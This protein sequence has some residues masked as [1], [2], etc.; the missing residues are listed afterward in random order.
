MMNGLLSTAKSQNFVVCIFFLRIDTWFA[1][2]LVPPG[3]TFEGQ[4][5]LQKVRP[6]LK[7]QQL[8]VD[9]FCDRNLVQKIVP[10]LEPVL[11]H[12]GID[13]AWLLAILIIWL[14]KKIEALSTY[15]VLLRLKIRSAPHKFLMMLL[16]TMGGQQQQQSVCHC[17]HTI[18][19]QEQHRV[20]R[21]RSNRMWRQ[22]FKLKFPLH[23]YVIGPEVENGWTRFLNDG[24]DEDMRHMWYSLR[25]TG[26]LFNT[27]W[28]K[29][30]FM[31]VVL[32]DKPRYF[33]HENTQPSW[34]LKHRVKDGEKDYH[35]RAR[36][37]TRRFFNINYMHWGK[38]WN[39][40]TGSEAMLYRVKQKMLG[41]CCAS[42]EIH[43]LGMMYIAA[44]VQAMLDN[45]P[46]T[47]RSDD[48]V[49]RSCDE[50][51]RL[52]EMHNVAVWFE[53]IVSNVIDKNIDAQS[54]SDSQIILSTSNSL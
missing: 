17:S 19:V 32:W 14:T 10:Y 28:M 45:G 51:L 31:T 26:S 18:D 34:P 2:I 41:E 36:K 33:D 30:N 12:M 53:I 15:S 50:L 9:I 4:I 20:V 24:Y 21:A 42:V 27:E 11:C 16:M 13:V 40:W 46:S 8:L 25:T 52:G 5:S 49:W 54:K 37:K 38:W 43:K 6:D 48:V 22:C 23:G 1:S 3:F 29:I 7:S 47:W 35:M 39:K 44:L